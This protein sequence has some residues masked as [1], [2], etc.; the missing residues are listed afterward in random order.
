MG[1]THPRCKQKYGIDGHMALYKYD[2]LFKKLLHSSKYQGAYLVLKELLS[3]PQENISKE[4]NK[5][6]LLF[7]PSIISIPLHPQRIKERGFNQSDIIRER[8]FGSE[9]LPNEVILKRAINTDHLANIGNK[10]KRKKHIRGAFI[11]VGKEIQKTILL[12]DD[13]ITSGS[14]M[15]ECSRIL[16]EHG[17]Q[18]VLAFSLAKG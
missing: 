1:L 3:Y 13:V 8:Y 15:L 4:I 5:W 7:N 11:H 6:I 2:G 16:K 17:V 9:Y 12:I 10:I 18:T 14:T